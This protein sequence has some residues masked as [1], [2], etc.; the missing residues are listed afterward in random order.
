VAATVTTGKATQP[1][2]I[3]QNPFTDNAVT[4]DDVPF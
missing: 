2:Q 1:E 3:G 4:E